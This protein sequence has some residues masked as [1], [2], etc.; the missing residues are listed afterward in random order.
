M[1]VS[2]EK[3]ELL[4]GPMEQGTQ[5]LG[6]AGDPGAAGRRGPAPGRGRGRPL[7]MTREAVLEKI[8]QLAAREEGIFRV[9]LTHSGLYARARRMFGSWA[10]ALEAAGVNYGQTVAHARGRAL[11]SRRNRA[12]RRRAAQET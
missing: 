1:T 6:R 5:V 4:D 12:A 3:V 7:L 11:R 2:S 10:A 8:R 9:H